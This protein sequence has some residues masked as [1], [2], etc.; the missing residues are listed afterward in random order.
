MS[1]VDT[2]LA[3]IDALIADG[4]SNTAA[5]VRALAAALHQLA[6]P[7]RHKPG[8]ADTPDDDF[9]TGVLDGKWTVV[10]G[11]EAAVSLLETGNVAR[12][13]VDTRL[14]WLLAQVGRDGARTVTIRQDY[15][16]PDGN[17]ILACV[18]YAAPFDGE[19]GLAGGNSEMTLEV[20]L[21]DTDSDPSAGNE[22]AI[23]IQAHGGGVRV[24]GL[25]NG[26]NVIGSAGF[27]AA[28]TA[29][30]FL[31]MGIVLLRIARSGSDYYTMFSLNGGATWIPCGAAR[32]PGST[33]T[34]VWLTISNA[35]A[36]TALVPICGVDW[37]RLGSNGVDPW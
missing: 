7:L 13:D 32:A 19:P 26:V 35:V 8:P 28:T 36:H 6:E 33:L 16:V 10:T 3:D 30:A 27:A 12:Y 14:G 4:G 11:T 24:R 1:F 22:V 34:N 17:S 25:H 9:D 5:D 18:A 2:T 29:A 21:N 31:G 20:T 23:A 37:I 15:T